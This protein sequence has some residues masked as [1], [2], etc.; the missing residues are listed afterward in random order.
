MDRTI[1]NA[2]EEGR[3]KDRDEIEENGREVGVKSYKEGG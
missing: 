3:R 1:M 2:E